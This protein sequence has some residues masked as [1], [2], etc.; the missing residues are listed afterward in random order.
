MTNFEVLERHQKP[1]VHWVGDGFISAANVRAIN[2]EWPQD[3]KKEDG[4][5]QKKWS[6][7]VL[8]PTAHAVVDAIAPAAVGQMVGIPGLIADPE[9]GGG[10]LHCIPCGGFLKMHRDYNAHPGR[11]WH[12]RVNLLIYLNETWHDGW[13]GQLQLGV[14]DDLKRISPIAGRC[15]VFTMLD[16]SW[17]GH[18]EPLA[19]PESV[20]R[21]SLALY[22]YTPEPP[23]EPAHTTIYRR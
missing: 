7:T 9:L 4:K 6:T 8:P 10:G 18:P 2:A 5:G 11:G 19:C 17:H 22:F 21:R 3:W 1:F 23:P 12:R 15:V 16:N 20:Q 14:D 13:A